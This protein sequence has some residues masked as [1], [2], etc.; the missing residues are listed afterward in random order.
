MSFEAR[1]SAGFF[2]STH[3]M[4][5]KPP[6][7]ASARDRL[8]ALGIEAV[9][10]RVEAGETQRELAASIGVGIGTLVAWLHLP[11]HEKRYEQ[12]KLASAEAFLD[13]GFEAVKAALPKSSKTDATA[14]RAFAQEC[15]R[16]A[17]LRNPR[18]V[19][20]TAHEHSGPNGGPMQVTEIRRTI[21]DPRSSDA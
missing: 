10:L 15:A 14:A 21:V 19:E 20:K 7:A 13:L 18:Y 12:A 2:I 9:C 4:A 17:A 1:R 3:P 6:A 8:D 16:R 5:K 11:E